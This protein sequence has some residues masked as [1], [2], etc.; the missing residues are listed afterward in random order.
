[1]LAITKINKSKK[2]QKKKLL[3]FFF[4]NLTDVFFIKLV[5]MN[6]NKSKFN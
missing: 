5:K 2:S 1:M 3:V 4:Q 6:I